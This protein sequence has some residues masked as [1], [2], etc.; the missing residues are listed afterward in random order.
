[1]L[2]SPPQPL[3]HL[4]VVL[5]VPLKDKVRPFS[6]TYDTAILHVP[7][8]L[9]GISYEMC[10]ITQ[11]RV[12]GG[13]QQ[14]LHRLLLVVG[15][16]RPCRQPKGRTLP[17]EHSVPAPGT[18]TTPQRHCALPLSRPQ[19][20]FDITEPSPTARTMRNGGMET[21]GSGPPAF[22]KERFR[23]GKR[24]ATPA[25]RGSASGHGRL[26]INP[27]PT[28]AAYSPN[29]TEDRGFPYEI[30]LCLILTTT[31]NTFGAQSCKKKKIKK[32]Q[33]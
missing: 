13:V 4:A 33:E 26:R 10:Q 16:A 24:R 5:R 31:F 21:R 2:R 14:S 27:S 11:V 12:R 7:L 29:T 3:K 23:K 18:A 25:A 6:S 20:H 8:Y 28:D 22:C 19:T 30:Y 32:S 1:M 17:G 9:S 15:D